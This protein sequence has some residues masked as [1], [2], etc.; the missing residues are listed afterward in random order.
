MC[1]EIKKELKD[2]W[3]WIYAGGML[4]LSILLYFRD[5]FPN[6]INAGV[7]ILFFIN[8][9]IYNIKVKVENKFQNRLRWGY[10]GVL[11]LLAIIYISIIS[12][13]LQISIILLLI[14][15]MTI[16]LG[17]III[18]FT[19]LNKSRGKVWLI[20]NYL[21]FAF[22][23]IIFFGII[24]TITI[25][26]GQDILT[27]ENNKIQDMTELIFF[28]VSVF[29]SNV[30]GYYPTGFSKWIMQIETITSYILHIIILGYLISKPKRED[31][32][33]KIKDISS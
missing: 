3:F 24:Y 25:G 30:I 10:F 31:S 32:M 4:V 26:F 8:Q 2:F 7:L 17:T 29:Y 6:T 14:L 1:K 23:L 12:Q 13:E 22:I 27:Q 11:F 15:I 9:L 5:N 21:F 20:I 19:N 33:E 18:Q 16:L 28:S